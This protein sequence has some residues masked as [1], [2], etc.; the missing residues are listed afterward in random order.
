[1]ILSKTII[2]EESW[3][4]STHK[5]SSNEPQAY[6][7]VIRNI[8]PIFLANNLGLSFFDYFLRVTPL[9]FRVKIWQPWLVGSTC[10]GDM[11]FKCSMCL[12]VIHAHL[13]AS[14]MCLCYL[15]LLLEN[16]KVAK[17]HKKYNKM[18]SNEPKALEGVTRSILPIFW[19]HFNM[20]VMCF[21]YLCFLL[22]NA[23]V[24]KAH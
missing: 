23:K 7:W 1:M 8:L 17:A 22:Q 11:P 14:V 13:D 24:A 9:Q 21:C 19:A 16:T 12:E 6:K 3:L 2:Q 5:M 15:C 10:W 18:G 4:V 20:P